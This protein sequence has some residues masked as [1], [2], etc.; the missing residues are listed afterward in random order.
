MRVAGGKWFKWLKKGDLTL[1]WKFERVFDMKI[2]GLPIQLRTPENISKIVNRYG[3]VLHVDEDI[4]KFTDLSCC[5]GR[6]LTE[7]R[8]LINEE[9]VIDYGIGKSIKIGIIVR[10]IIIAPFNDDEAWG[11]NNNQMGDDNESIDEGSENDKSESDS[12]MDGIS[13]TWINNDNEVREE[14]EI[15]VD[16][17]MDTNENSGESPATEGMPE[18]D[19]SAIMAENGVCETLGSIKVVEESHLCIEIGTG[20]NLNDSLRRGHVAGFNKELNNMDAPITQ[21]PNYNSEGRPLNIHVG[22]APT[23]AHVAPRSLPKLPVSPQS[24]KSTSPFEVDHSNDKQ[25]KVR[26]A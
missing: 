15:P 14:G 24:F 6:I 1:N 23:L 10:E 20:G 4:W 7:S 17:N 8:V 26:P 21:S 18:V 3:K 5:E 25:R 12:E 16:V 2:V 22:L 9:V 13:D 19:E 11:G